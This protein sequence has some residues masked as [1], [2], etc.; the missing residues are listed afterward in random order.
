VCAALLPESEPGPPFRRQLKTFFATYGDEARE[1][2]FPF[3]HPLPFQF[4]EDTEAASHAD[5]F[6]L[7]DEMLI[8]PITSPAGSR[9]VYLPRG[10]WTSFETGEVFPGRR[11]IHV[12]STGLPMFARNGTIMPLDGLT[13]DEPM[14]LHYFP[15]LG[16]EFFLLETEL[17]DWSQVH[18]APAA[19]IMRLEIESKVARRYEWIVHHAQKPLRV[20]FESDRYAEVGSHEVLRDR[21]WYYDAVTKSLHVRLQVDA[22]ADAIVNLI[23]PE[24][25]DN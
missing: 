14:Q 18:A 17:S 20:E 22:G 25:I 6:L 10:R 8:A 15:S 7:G 4:P 1:R 13:S 16:A 21:T 5:E 9:D 24:P 2:G 12:S 3:F 11:T 23:L 19:D